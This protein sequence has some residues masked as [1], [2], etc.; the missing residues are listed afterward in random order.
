MRARGAQGAI[1]ADNLDAELG[2]GVRTPA[3]LYMAFQA[4]SVMA[5]QLPA[6]ANHAIKFVPRILAD[7]VS[8]EALAASGGT[9]GTNLA[10]TRTAPAAA[11][12]RGLIKLSLEPQ[13]ADFMQETAAHEAFHVVQDYLASY[14][15]SA[16]SQIK[17][18]FRDGMSLADVEGTL[19]RKLELARAPT[20]GSYWSTLQKAFGTK[21]FS[22]EEMQAY[23]FGAL[24]DANRRGVPM[25]GIKPPTRGWSW[26]SGSSSRDS[27]ARCAATGSPT[28]PIC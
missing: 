26:R 8:P 28:P 2:S 15:Q 7:E 17:R 3:Q 20:G 22:S 24:A 10:A 13:F 14:D 19:R 9:G 6:G 18:D 16:A 25:T 1:L 23:I 21:T 11:G 27:A 12:L 5:I 4:S